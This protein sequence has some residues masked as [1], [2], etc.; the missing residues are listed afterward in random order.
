M[1]L[2]WGTL[3]K[4]CSL[5][6]ASIEDLNVAASDYRLFVSMKKV[7]GG[8][9]L[10]SDME[11][12]LHQAFRNLLRVGINKYFATKLVVWRK[13]FILFCKYYCT[14]YF[15]KFMKWHR[16]VQPIY[17]GCIL[18]VPFLESGDKTGTFSWGLQKPL[19]DFNNQLVNQGQHIGP[20]WRPQRQTVLTAVCPG[21]KRREK[22]RGIVL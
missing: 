11:T 4:C 22:K 2:S 9:K 10:A 12:L 21:E 1:L 15:K 6:S 14:M 3:H 18:W 13:N 5:W 16:F 17:A 8:S 20:N 7:L 19:R